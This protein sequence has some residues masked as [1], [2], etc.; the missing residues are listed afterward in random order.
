MRTRASVLPK[1]AAKRLS[2]DCDDAFGNAAVAV[3]RSQES[4]QLLRRLRFGLP[5]FGLD[6][7]CKRTGLFSGPPLA[8]PT[9]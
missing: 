4:R 5:A 7:P 9:P 8:A 6:E 2:G 3:D 1:L